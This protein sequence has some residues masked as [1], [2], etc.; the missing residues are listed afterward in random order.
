M[1]MKKIKILA[2]IFIVSLPFT[3]VHA[4]GIFIVCK[5]PST[6]MTGKGG[7][8][9]AYNPTP[10]KVCSGKDGKICSTLSLE[11][12]CYKV[13]EETGKNYNRYS[14]GLGTFKTRDA[15]MDACKKEYGGKFEK[16]GGKC[17]KKVHE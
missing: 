10:D 15:C 9:N 11:D 2:V 7:C 1:S 8:I 5:A 12:L 13:G 14:S 6:G 4:E 16:F 17:F 3:V